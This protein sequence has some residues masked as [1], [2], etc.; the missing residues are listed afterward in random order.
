MQAAQCNSFYAKYSCD[1]APLPH[2]VGQSCV[3]STDL[4]VVNCYGFVRANLQDANGTFELAL[5]TV[6]KSRIEEASVMSPQLTNMMGERH[7][8]A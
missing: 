1:A 4:A 6:A 2:G 7:H 5:A 3:R 8:L